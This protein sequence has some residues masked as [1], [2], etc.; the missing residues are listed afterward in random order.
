MHRHKRGTLTRNIGVSA[1][2]LV[3]VLG[4]A[5]CSSDGTDNA[6]VASLSN[7]SPS[8]VAASASVPAG[9]EKDS[10]LDLNSTKDMTGVVTTV[11][12]NK[13]PY[14]DHLPDICQFI[15]DSVVQQLG[16][17]RKKKGFTGTRLITQGCVIQPPL[18]ELTFSINAA[19]YVNNIRELLTRPENR[20]FRSNVE[21]A[22]S[23]RGTAFQDTGVDLN[24]GRGY[25]NCR[26]A[27]GT[28]YGAAVISFDINP[29]YKANTCE[30][31]ISAA[32][33]I[34]PFMPKSPSQMRSTP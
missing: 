18:G 30:R 5:A 7:P 28:F 13:S 4:I 10:V 26:V 1:L 25:E 21:I 23:L 32:Q 11:P 12:I 14:I 9:V 17:T 15:P 3:A 33:E 29:G 2:G 34:A 16:A 8:S 6:P 24:D 27:W 19:I 20:I 31:A 22:S